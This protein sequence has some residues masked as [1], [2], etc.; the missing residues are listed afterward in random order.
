MTVGHL[1]PRVLVP[2]AHAAISRAVV[3]VLAHLYSG[4]RHVAAGAGD[5][6]VGAAI[7]FKGARNVLQCGGEAGAPVLDR[8]LRLQDEPAGAS[9]GT[10]AE[11]ASDRVGRI[12]RREVIALPGG[13]HGVGASCPDNG[14]SHGDAESC[15]GGYRNAGTRVLHVSSKIVSPID[16]MLFA[17]PLRL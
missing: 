4:L 12:G 10:L 14:A 9:P 8:G 13:R 1:R 3:A 2:G 6:V 16:L 11:G 17:L 15:H 5:V 7:R